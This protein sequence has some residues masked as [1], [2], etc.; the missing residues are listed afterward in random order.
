M[1]AGRLA[2][3][4]V[5]LE[6]VRTTDSIGGAVIIYRERGRAWA[7]VWPSSGSETREAGGTQAMVMHE[8]R[9]RKLAQPSL[10]AD[11]RLRFGSRTFEILS[12]LNVEERGE[13]W[14][15]LCVE[16]PA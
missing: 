1:Q 9:M 3:R 6:P 7:S 15:L 5:L 11:W 13:Q 10:A 12:V 14:R 4:C 16:R 8:V 2:S